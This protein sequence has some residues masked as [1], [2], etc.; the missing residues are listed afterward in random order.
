M[1]IKSYIAENNI[2]VL[3]KNLNL[4]YGENLGLKNDFR[5]KIKLKFK[6]TEI[7]YYLPIPWVINI[8]LRSIK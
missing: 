8:P 2:E 1:L 6:D 4:F 3:N 7:I 5:K